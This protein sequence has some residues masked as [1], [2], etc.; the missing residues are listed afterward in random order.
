MGGSYKWPSVSSVVEYRRNVRNLVL[1]V[2]HD[3]PLQLPVTMES[4][5][6]GHSSLS[7]ASLECYP[8]LID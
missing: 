7:N 1:K 3:T 8:L 6:V 2:I 5:W 4:P